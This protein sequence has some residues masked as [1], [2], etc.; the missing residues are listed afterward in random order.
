[1]A[2]VISRFRQAV[3]TNLEHIWAAPPPFA[4][5]TPAA[6]ATDFLAPAI[7][8][9]H[10][11]K[12]TRALF[13]LAGFQA[14]CSAAPD[15][16]EEM[17]TSELPVAL[18]SVLELYQLSALIHDDVIDGA[19][20]RRGVP[21]AHVAYAQWHR[22]HSLLGSAPSFGEKMAVLLGDYVLSLASYTL[23]SGISPAA[24]HRPLTTSHRSP[25]A[26]QNVCEHGVRELFHAMCTEV[27]FGQY[28][29]ALSEF[30]PLSLHGSAAMERALAVLYH[31]AARYSVLVP[32]LLGAQ[33]A[34]AHQTLSAST[35]QP[36]ILT[37]LESICLPL[38]EAFQLRDDAL[39]IFGDPHATGKPAGDDL[40]EGKRTVLIAL[41]R[42][43]A[44]P[45]ERGTID[46]LLGIGRQLSAEE[47]AQARSIIVGCGAYARHEELIA[48]REAHVNSAIAR[49][50]LELSVLQE[51]AAS[52][53]GRTH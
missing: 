21:T 44:L 22:A 8:L 18:G 15:T 34:L 11:G 28:T 41:T 14:G 25:A 12:R 29:D 17:P 24:S 36:D 50:S 42:E 45:Q 31:K 6:L 7:A 5:H 1:M 53:V 47:L 16:L 38:G 27:A 33:L 23:E 43:M 49:S 48:E 3:N 30:E 37:E 52:L 46:A 20:M 51:L 13:A 9:S 40:A 10:G 26:S 35:A 2:S 4:M 32:T 39:G 19:S